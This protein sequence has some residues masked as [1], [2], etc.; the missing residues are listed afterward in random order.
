VKKIWNLLENEP[1]FPSL[2]EIGYTLSSVETDAYDVL[3]CGLEHIEYA[4]AVVNPLEC[5]IIVALE[6]PEMERHLVPN[7][8]NAWIDRNRLARLPA[9][10][11]AYQSHIDEKIKFRENHTLLER[12]IIDTSVHHENLNVIKSSMRE[13][14]K[15]IEKIFEARVEEMRSIHT[16]TAN[17]LDQLSHLKEQ[18][19]PKVFE[20]LEESWAMT[21]SILGRTD[22]VI[23][24]MFG[25]VMVL[26]CED[27]I[28]QMID[29]IG[30]IMDDDIFY[31]R[32][33]G[34]L[35]NNEKEAQLKERLVPFYTIQDQRD[36]AIGLNTPAQGCKPESVDIDDFI[37]F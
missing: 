33:N 31:A 1:S 18:I 34:C 22:D 24:A 16:D 26:Q 6:N 21:R 36:Y 8:F 9:M 23:K 25:F 27:R 15:E 7:T 11:K 29:G 4:G 14:T 32:D 13:S 12:L 17:T 35:I 3:V 37:L 5:F 10:L 30:N 20:N 2:E 28:S 19:N